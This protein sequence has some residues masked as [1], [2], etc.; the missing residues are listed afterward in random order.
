MQ[1]IQ[2]DDLWILAANL[3]KKKDSFQTSILLVGISALNEKE[4]RDQTNDK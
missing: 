2:N 3:K 1:L 4:K